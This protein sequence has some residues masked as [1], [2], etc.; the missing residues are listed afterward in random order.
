MYV[1]SSGLLPEGFQSRGAIGSLRVEPRH[2]DDCAMGLLLTAAP[3]GAERPTDTRSGCGNDLRPSSDGCPSQAG[4]A[5]DGDDG[6]DKPKWGGL[7][8]ARGGR[9]RNRTPI[10]NFL[11]RGK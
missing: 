7:Q 3:S 9:V 2:R 10:W 6:D 11:L 4:E 1:W 8:R 5:L